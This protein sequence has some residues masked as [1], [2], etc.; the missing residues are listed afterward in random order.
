MQLGLC[1][2]I[3]AV[4]LFAVDEAERSSKT[5]EIIEIAAE[6]N[7]LFPIKVCTAFYILKC[8]ETATDNVMKTFLGKFFIL[9]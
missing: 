3:K 8:F 1:Q 2:Q 6:Q 4:C 9:L 7:L 5:H